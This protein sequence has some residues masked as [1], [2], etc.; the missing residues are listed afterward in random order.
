M[1]PDAP[2]WGS[3]SFL[4]NIIVNVLLPNEINDV[5]GELMCLLILGQRKSNLLGEAGQKRTWQEQLPVYSVKQL[6]VDK[7]QH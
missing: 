5:E 7:R 2:I 6:Q 3:T 4:A 1:C